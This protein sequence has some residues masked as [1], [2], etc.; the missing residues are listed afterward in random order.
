MQ[1]SDKP[2]GHSLTHFDKCEQL[3][4]QPAPCV[5]SGMFPSF[6]PRMADGLLSPSVQ[7]SSVT[8]SCLTLRSPMDCGTPGLPVHHQ[9]PEFT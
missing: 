1:C 9:L 5:P 3:C 2:P 8:Q 6:F 7:L 4:V